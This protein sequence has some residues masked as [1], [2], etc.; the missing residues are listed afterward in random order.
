MKYLFIFILILV[1]ILNRK[2]EN[3]RDISTKL[4]FRCCK[5]F[6]CD[7]P[8]CYN[9]LINNTPYKPLNRNINR[10]NEFGKY[11][12]LLYNNKNNYISPQIL[13]SPNYLIL[14]KRFKSKNRWSY[15]VNNKNKLI[16]LKDYD[17]IKTENIKYVIYNNKKYYFN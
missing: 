8:I 2:I 7:N 5:Y 13:N 4:Y 16:K 12:E 9:Y 11:G 17:N 14:H 15:Y 6:G 3:F 1:L 10:R